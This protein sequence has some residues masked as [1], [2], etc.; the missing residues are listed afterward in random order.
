MHNVLS[1]VG[2]ASLYLPH[3]V[4]KVDTKWHRQSHFVPKSFRTDLDH[5]KIRQ[6]KVC[7][8]L[9]AEIKKGR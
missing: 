3:F 2:L 6:T 9:H 5:F 8:R 1:G 4:E 7:F